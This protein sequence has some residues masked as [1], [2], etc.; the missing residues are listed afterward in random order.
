MDLQRA[1]ANPLIRP[2]DVRPTRPDMDVIGVFNPAAT[3]FGD[4]TLLLLRVAEAVR[5]VPDRELAVPMV[6][7]RGD[8]AV[9]RIERIRRDTPHLDLSDTR[10]I[11]LRDRLLLTSLSHLRL[12][13]S[14]DGV[15][16]TIDET[17]ALYPRD[18]AEEYGLED[19]RITRIDETYFI[20]YTAVSRWGIAVG[21]ASTTDFVTYQRHGLIFGP[22]NKDV[23]LF[24]ARMGERFFALHRPAVIGLGELQIWLASSPDLYHWGRHT[25]LLSQRRG[26]WDALRIG[27]GDVPVRTDDGWLTLY[28]GV[29]AE[30]GYCL[31]AALLDVQHPS[32]LLA[33]SAEP[34]MIPEAEYECRGFFDHVVFTC[35]S[36][37]DDAG[38]LHIYYGAADAC[39]CRASVP[40]ADVLATLERPR[41]NFSAA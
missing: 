6:D 24:P 33:R 15:T 17:P 22:E 14:R 34:V 5:D 20:T 11:R 1:A 31:G 27:A 13:R 36:V 30:H 32:R 12:A 9:L 10:M 25:P 26:Y 23:V 40:V 18:R 29:N 28:H 41:R 37:L 8:E 7:C 16:F 39:T 4:E 35:G 38:M 2:Q 19:P 3:R 21:L